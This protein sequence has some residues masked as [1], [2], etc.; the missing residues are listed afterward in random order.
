M[1]LNFVLSQKR[2]KKLLYNNFVYREYYK[3]K[4]SVHWRCELFETKN[5]KAKIVTTSDKKSGKVINSDVTINS[6]V[7]ESCDIEVLIVKSKIKKKC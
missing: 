6:H 2:K 4:D 7:T 3:G 5:G 1:S